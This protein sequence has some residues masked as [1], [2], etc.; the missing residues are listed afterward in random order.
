MLTRIDKALTAGGSAALLV[1]GTAAHSSDGLGLTSVELAVGTF[2]VV[3]FLTWLIPN[4][5]KA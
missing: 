2:L 4:K 1:L 3:G 5:A